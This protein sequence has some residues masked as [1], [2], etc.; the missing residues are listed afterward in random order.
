MSGF[1]PGTANSNS[2]SIQAGATGYTIAEVL[3]GTATTKTLTMMFAGGLR[4]TSPTGNAV[5]ILDKAGSGNEADLV[6]TNAGTARWRILGGDGAAEAGSNTGSNFYIQG[7]NDA[8]AV[9][10]APVLLTR[11]TGD[12]S[13]G[14]NLWMNNGQIIVRPSSQL[15]NLN[16]TLA[17]STTVTL[18]QGQYVSFGGSGMVIANNPANGT[19]VM[20][21]MGAG[22]TFLVGGDTTNYSNAATAGKT[23]LYYSAGAYAFVNNT[24][25]TQTY[26][27]FWIKTRENP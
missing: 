4:F 2:L 14:N 12:V 5:F 13:L 19:I 10:N 3:N 27:L 15:G 1:P 9:I 21:L 22:A 18:A 17:N 16:A 7:C 25:G 23:N 11:S 8:G 6:F 24:S 20:F 26:S